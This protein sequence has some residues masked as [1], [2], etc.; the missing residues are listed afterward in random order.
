M[1]FTMK[2]TSYE[3]REKPALARLREVVGEAP[4]AHTWTIWG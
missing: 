2:T 3:R 4:V 1:R